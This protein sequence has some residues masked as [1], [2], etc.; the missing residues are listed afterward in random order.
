M[1]RVTKNSAFFYDLRTRIDEHRAG[2]IATFQPRTDV[3][4]NRTPS[5]KAWDILQC[6]DHLNLT[7][8]DHDELQLNQAQR[9]LASEPTGNE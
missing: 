1:P 8:V 9:V 7:R 2:V 3:Q 4:F 6:F 5:P